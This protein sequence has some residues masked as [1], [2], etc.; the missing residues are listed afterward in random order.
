MILMILTMIILL[1][2]MGMVLMKWTKCTKKKEVSDYKKIKSQSLLSRCTWA[3]MQFTPVN[4][5]I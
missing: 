3:V 4:F 2:I 1:M 5:I